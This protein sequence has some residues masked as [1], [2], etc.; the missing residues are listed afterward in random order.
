MLVFAAVSSK[1][2]KRVESMKRW[3]MRRKNPRFRATSVRV[4]SSAIRLPKKLRRRRHLVQRV[5]ERLCASSEV[6]ENAGAI[7]ILVGRRAGVGV[8]HPMSEGVVEQ[9]GDLACG[10]SHRFGFADTCGE[11]SI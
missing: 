3:A 10:C 11:P 9:G 1:N 7:S 5:A 4:C 8:V 6:G 2:M